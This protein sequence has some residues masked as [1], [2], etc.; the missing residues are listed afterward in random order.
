V[1]SKRREGFVEVTMN[2]RFSAATLV[3]VAAMLLGGPMRQGADAQVNQPI[4]PAY[5]GYLRNPDGSYTLSFA[6]FSHNADVVTVPSGPA[7]GFS[8]DPGDR[9]Q[10]ITFRPGHWR[11]QCVMVVDANFDGKLIWTLTY[12]GTT[13]GT[14]QQM[15]QSNWNLVEGA[16]ELKLIDY[17]KVPRGICLNRAPV[18]RVLGAI[19]AGG[20]GAVPALSAAVKEEMSLF[21]SVNDEGLPRG[22]NLKVAWKQLSGPGTVKFRDPGAARTHASFSAPGTYELEL[23]ASDSALENS[24]KVAVHVK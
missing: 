11:F 12:A 9:Q 14:S 15:L 22:Q 16:A 18:V 21:G 7:N 2:L 23:W 1:C 13:T 17:A 19:A 20:R 24:T 8:P 5:D 6:Y 3:L 4:Y 10:P